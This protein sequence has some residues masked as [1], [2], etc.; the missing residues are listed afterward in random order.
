MPGAR[1]TRS[2]ARKV[3]KRTSN[4]PQVRRNIPAFPARWF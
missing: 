1:R 3:K 2:L 4:S